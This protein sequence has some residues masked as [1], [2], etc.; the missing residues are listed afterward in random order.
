MNWANMETECIYTFFCDDLLTSS[1]DLTGLYLHISGLLQ[2]KDIILHFSSHPTLNKRPL[3]NKSSAVEPF[4]STRIVFTPTPTV[5]LL[6]RISTQ[7]SRISITLSIH[8]TCRHQRLRRSPI[9]DPI[10]HGVESPRWVGASA[11]KTMI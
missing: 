5:V 8:Q 4:S 10:P 11:P 2:Y 1:K 9:L 3:Q 6:L 7:W